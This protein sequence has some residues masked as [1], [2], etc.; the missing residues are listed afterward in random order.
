MIKT[1]TT[2]EILTIY[3]WYMSIKEEKPEIISNCSVAVQWGLR[4][5]MNKFL[6]IA[7]DFMEMKSELEQKLQAEYATEEKSEVIEG[8]EAQRKVKEEYLEEYQKAIEE[9]NKSLTEILSEENEIDIKVVD[10]DN[11]VEK[12]LSDKTPTTDEIDF[13][14]GLMFMNKE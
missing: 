3:N 14:D 1:F 2:N 8:E 5:N 7:K 11:E 4:Q 13:F 6:P 12:T 10:V 9:I